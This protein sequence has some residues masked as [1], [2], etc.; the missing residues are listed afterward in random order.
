[1][2]KKFFIL[3]LLTN[4]YKIQAGFLERFMSNMADHS[5][6]LSI[7]ELPQ[8]SS[9]I[10]P[11]LAESTKPLRSRLYNNF[12]FEKPEV[13]PSEHYKID[14][15]IYPELADFIDKNA[16]RQRI[17]DDLNELRSKEFTEKLQRYKDLEDFEVMAEADE[18]IRNPQPPKDL[19]FNDVQSEEVKENVSGNYNEEITD[20]KGTKHTNKYVLKGTAIDRIINANKI[21]KVIREH[22]LKHVGVPEKYVT[23]IGNKWEILV[24]DI[25]EDPNSKLSQEEAQEIKIIMNKTGYNDFN[26]SLMRDKRT[27]KIM[28]T[29]TE[30]SSFNDSLWN[31]LKSYFSKP[32]SLSIDDR[33]KKQFKLLADYENAKQELEERISYRKQLANGVINDLYESILIEVYNNISDKLYEDKQRNNMNRIN[34]RNIP[35]LEENIKR[36]QKEIKEFEKNSLKEKQQ[37]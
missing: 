12:F 5:A 26:M 31:S 4:G 1:M 23:K 9:T 37:L 28:I 32:K 34:E 8:N 18:R 36:L 15:K 13:T 14:K 29:N 22:N 33:I 17:I 24:E 19:S 20:Q 25:Q 11:V 2:K 10:K 7:D 16:Y 3:L 21:K 35:L 6:D 27:G 30:G